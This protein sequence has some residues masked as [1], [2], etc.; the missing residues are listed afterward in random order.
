MLLFL[1]RTCISC[2]IG[3]TSMEFPDILLIF[4]SDTD[5]QRTPFEILKREMNN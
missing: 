5:G 2:V 1:L 3:A 4:F